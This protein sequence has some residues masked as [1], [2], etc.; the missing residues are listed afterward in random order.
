MQAATKKLPNGYLQV[1]NRPGSDNTHQPVLADQV[2]DL[3]AV[4]PEGNYIDLTVGS[5]GHLRRLVDR[6]G[7]AAH[8]FGVDRDPAAIDRARLNL[9]G[10][11]P[12]S[13]LIHSGYADLAQLAETL[14]VS[15]FHG[16]LLDLGLSSDQLNAPDR[17]FAFRLEGPLDMRFDPGSDLPSAAELIGAVDEKVLTKI[18]LE[19]GQER[20]ARKIAQAIVRE[21]QNQV[22]TSTADLAAIVSRCTAPDRRSKSLAR[23]FQALRIAVNRELEQ[24]VAV[25]PVILQLLLPGGRLAAI[26]YHSL[27]DR[28]VKQFIAEHS[29]SCLC[30]PR[31]PIC[32]CNHR[33]TLKAI[34]RGGFVPDQE[35]I[36]KNPRAR[37]ARLRVAER[38]A[39]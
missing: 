7:S 13:H 3:L 4:N 14:G 28:L 11:V 23:V 32:I 2:A 18:L 33:A 36:E 9:K 26:T 15:G 37:S 16:V 29:R 24:L 30:P 35:E 6:V 34:G 19:F 17:G 39:L 31:V 25:L 1:M 5:G 21:R 12:S 8:C 22:I 38:L 20:A 27:E 10:I